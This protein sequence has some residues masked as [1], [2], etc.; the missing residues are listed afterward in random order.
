MWPADTL[1][2]EQY[3]QHWQLV[4]GVLHCTTDADA[5]IYE[6]KGAVS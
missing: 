4:A 3:V 5:D 2:K 1:F 6:S